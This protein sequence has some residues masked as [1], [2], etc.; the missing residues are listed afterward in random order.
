MDEDKRKQELETEVERLQED[1]AETYQTSGDLAFFLKITNTKIVK[2][3]RLRLAMSL[4]P[5]RI[6]SIAQ[7]QAH[8][9][10]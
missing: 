3:N 4:N 9:R 6:Y 2:K 7:R 10:T 8:I 5:T 1:C